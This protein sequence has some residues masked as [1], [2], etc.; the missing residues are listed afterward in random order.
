MNFKDHHGEVYEKEIQ[1]QRPKWKNNRKN[2]YWRI[3][4]ERRRRTLVKSDK[5]PTKRT[6]RRSTDEDVLIIQTWIAD[7]QLNYYFHLSFL[8]FPSPIFNESLNSDKCNIDWMKIDLLP[9]NRYSPKTWR[10]S[11]VTQYSTPGTTR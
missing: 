8:L 3:V 10:W 5:Y 4:S 6:S 9:R 1:P 2:N 11:R 7:F